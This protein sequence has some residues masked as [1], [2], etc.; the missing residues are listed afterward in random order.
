MR[1]LVSLGAE[2][3]ANDAVLASLARE[4]ELIV[5]HGP[6]RFEALGLSLRNAL[7]ERDVVDVLAHVVLGA[8]DGAV[9]D[10]DAAEPRAIVELRSLRALIEAGSL[11]ICEIA[12]RP[13][14]VDGIGEMRPVEADVDADLAAALLAR[15]LDADLFLLLGDGAEGRSRAAERFAAATGRRAAVGA[16]ALAAGLAAVDGS[17]VPGRYAP[18]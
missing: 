17:A 10:G 6:D 16:P 7:P 2:G 14:A 3:G 8:E 15:R 9:A 5:S 11:V 4:H 18:A 1:I 12:P 13:L